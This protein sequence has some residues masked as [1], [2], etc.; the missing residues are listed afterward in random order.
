VQAA[1]HRMAGIGG[2]GGIG[3]MVV[4]SIT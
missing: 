3:G 1:D 4:A 2:I